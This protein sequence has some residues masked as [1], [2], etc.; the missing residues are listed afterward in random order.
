MTNS[1]S[2]KKFRSRNKKLCFGP[3]H[4]PDCV[5]IVDTERKSSVVNEAARLQIPIVGLV[6]STVPREVFEKITYPIPCNDSVQFVYL[7]CNLITK[8]FLLE[9][10]N[11][12][13]G[14]E[15][16]GSSDG[17]SSS[18]EAKPI[19]ESNQSADETKVV[20]YSA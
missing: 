12:G 4:P 19:E 14:N 2:P 3:V 20:L 8:T 6:D 13:G 1:A 10:K 15:T 18:G 17:G 16:G 11:S 5:V 9:Q 7:V